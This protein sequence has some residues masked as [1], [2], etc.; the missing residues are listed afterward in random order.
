M[1]G[2]ASLES[3]EPPGG[4]SPDRQPF[5][6]EI[7]AAA[8]R[9]GTLFV[10]S[11]CIRASVDAFSDPASP[12]ERLTVLIETTQPGHLV[13]I[14]LASSVGEMRIVWSKWNEVHTPAPYAIA[15]VVL[16]PAP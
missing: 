13:D 1:S 12:Q 15:A 10:G 16:V 2:V 14:L 3:A 6:L 8:P 9:P 5:T 7:E 4:M 11:A